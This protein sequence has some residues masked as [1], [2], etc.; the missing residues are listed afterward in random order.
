MIRIERAFRAVA[1]ALFVRRP[2]VVAVP[3]PA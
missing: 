1:S 2:L 3:H